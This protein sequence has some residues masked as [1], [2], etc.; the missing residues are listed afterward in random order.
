MWGVLSSFR[1]DVLSNPELQKLLADNPWIVPVAWVLGG[2][3]LG[4]L[5]EKALLGYLQRLV[6]RTKRKTDEAIISSLHGLPWI[7]CILGGMDAAIDAMNLRPRLDT[8]L[9]NSI[10]GL[11]IL[12][13]TVGVARLVTNL[14]SV[15]SGHPDGRFPSTSILRNLAAIVVYLL[16]F[17]VILQTLG[18]SIT[19]VLTALG[20]GGLAVALALQDTLANLFAGIQIIASH[21]VKVGDYIKL[22]TGE[23]GYVTDIGW[24]HTMVRG[25]SNNMFVLPNSKLATT[26]T[27][28][29]YQPEQ[30]LSVVINLGVAYDSDLEKVEQITIEVAREVMQQVQGGVPT[31]APFIR[32][33]EFGGSSINFSVILRG[34]EFTDQYLIKHEFI[35]RLTARY[36]KEGINI[37]FPIQTVYMHQPEQLN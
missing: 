15:Y 21:Q 20:V 11:V 1:S 26:V 7:W 28:N 13:I 14:T 3:A 12:S 19:P 30:E 5:I 29:Y 22:A 33:N 24:R 2:I 9:V 36:R 27:T 6:K 16:G 23:E 32:Y 8:I 35:K 31:H 25:L 17:L 34:K 37:P 18:I 4:W 10:V